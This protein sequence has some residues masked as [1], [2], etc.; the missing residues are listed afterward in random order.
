[1]CVKLKEP[2]A[3]VK[4]ID[5]V[6][7]E[8]PVEPKV[9]AGNDEWNL[10]RKDLSEYRTKKAKWKDE[11]TYFKKNQSQ[12]MADYDRKRRQ[13]AKKLA[14]YQAKVVNPAKGMVCTYCSNTT[15]HIFFCRDAVPSI[16]KELLKRYNGEND[17]ADQS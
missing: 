3:P 8:K 1:M 7:P 15:T 5:P 9:G 12:L 16:M 14:E 13:H 4:P 10:Y 11:H 17:G 2:A 6:K